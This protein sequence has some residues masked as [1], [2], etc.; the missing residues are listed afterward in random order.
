[1]SY[2]VG[3]LSLNT[4]EAEEMIQS[5]SFGAAKGFVFIEVSWTFI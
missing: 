4:L 3:A 1:M 5:M 2:I